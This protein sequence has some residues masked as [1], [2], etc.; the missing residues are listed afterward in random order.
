M[1]YISH[2]LGYPL[3][4][5][6]KAT[7]G[8]VLKDDTLPD[9]DRRLI[10][11]RQQLGKTSTAK[12][13]ALKALVMNDHRAHG[14]LMYHGASTG[15]WSG[16]HFQPQNLP[17]PSFKNTDVCIE[18]FQYQN[19]QLLEMIYNDSMEALSSCLRGR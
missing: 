13:A 14:L 11:I 17:R 7:L 8:E 6:D 1:D 15:R 5:F 18:L 3:M 10:E 4:Q 9:T 19:A 12:Y 2:D 16:R